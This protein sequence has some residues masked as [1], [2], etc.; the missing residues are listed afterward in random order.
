M[1][2]NDVDRSSSSSC[3]TALKTKLS[4][5]VN[6]HEQCQEISD[7]WIPTRLIDII[8][9]SSSCMARVVHRDA[10]ARDQPYEALRYLTLS[11]MW[12]KYDFL[13]LTTSNFHQLSW[14]FPVSQLPRTFRD[15]ITVA[16]RLGLRY[17][18]IDSLC[19]LQDSK[20]DWSVESGL[21]H[22][23]YMNVFCNIASS[24]SQ[25]PEEGL[26]WERNSALAGSFTVQFQLG[27]YNQEFDVDLDLQE[28][29]LRHSPLYKRGWVLQE[30]CL[31]PRTIHFSRFPAF[32]CRIFLASES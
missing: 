2:E 26:F 15:A 18:W 22:K 31:S 24:L 9:Y 30:S 23:V 28:T 19:I 8:E 29:T 11:H 32:E 16:C 4:D 12:G 25:C 10:A 21:M 3:L 13:V 17:L 6:M 27:H 20:D 5:C 7:G 14:E 1:P